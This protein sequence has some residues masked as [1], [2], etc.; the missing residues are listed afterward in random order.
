MKLKER[1][2]LLLCL[3]L[4]VITILLVGCD[5]GATATLSSA[6]TTIAPVTKQTTTTSVMTGTTQVTTTSAVTGT[7]QVTTTSAVT[8]TTQV[9]TAPVMTGT[10][11]PIIG[12]VAPTLVATSG[13]TMKEAYTLVESQIKAWQTDQLLFSI[14]NSMDTD[15]GVGIDSE[16]RSVEWNFQAISPKL[17]KRATWLVKSSSNSKPSVTKTGEEDLTPADTTSTLALPPVN[18][19]IDSNQL[20]TIARQN[21]GDKSDTPVGFYLMQPIK[22]GDPLAV[23]LVFYKGNDVVRLRIDMQ[24]GKLVQNDKG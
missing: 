23:D 8:G 18:S 24:S 7:T 13:L 14:F 17:N 12:G 22:T 3:V 10:T 16:G 19:L 9:T 21:G 11:T 6:V 4:P 15:S 2:N 20:M 5:G 1:K